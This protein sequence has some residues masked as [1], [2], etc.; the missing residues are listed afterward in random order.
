MGLPRDRPISK[1]QPNLL[2]PKKKT[3]SPVKKSTEM[4]ALQLTSGALRLL[5]SEKLK[6]PMSL[7][8]LP[9]G[10]AMGQATGQG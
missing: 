9:M 4:L 7:A 3:S 8:L 1:C 5:S 2:I 10:R 6:T